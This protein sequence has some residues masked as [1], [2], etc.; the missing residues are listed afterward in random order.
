MP[1]KK[2]Q[3]QFEMSDLGEK[4]LVYYEDTRTKSNDGGLKHMKVD[5]KIVWVHPNNVNK[6]C[7]PI[8]LVEKYLFLPTEF[9]KTDSKVMVCRTSCGLK[10]YIQGH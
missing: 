4:C 7:C 3:L 1:N 10:H 6:D 8:R 2:S 5:R 9:A